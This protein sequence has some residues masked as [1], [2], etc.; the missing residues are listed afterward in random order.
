MMPLCQKKE[1]NL[2]EMGWWCKNKNDEKIFTRKHYYNIN[3]IENIKKVFIKTNNTG[4]FTSA[5]MYNEDNV[6]NDTYAYGDLYFDFDCKE[7]FEKVR[8]DVLKTLAYLDVV[9]KIKSDSVYI[10]F[11]GNKGIHITIPAYYFNIEPCVNLNGI[12]KSIILNIKKYTEY[13]TLDTQIYDKKRLYRI[14]NSIH[15][16]TNLYKIQ[17]TAKEIES[18]EYEK[19]LEMAKSPRKFSIN[20]NY[21]K[22]VCEKRFIEMKKNFEENCNRNDNIKYNQRINFVPPCIKN[23]LISG[24]KEGFRN[25]TIAVLASFYKSAGKDLNSTINELTKWNEDKNLPPTKQNELVQTIRSIFFGKAQYGCSTIKELTE[26]NQKEC[27]F[28]K[29][30]N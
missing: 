2:I 25:N 8:K 24:A 21:D 10:Y 3:D 16:K 30:S 26:C 11:S 20:H 19:I 18:L 9:F 27:K 14:P 17:L 12:F 22:Q 1:C 4:I 7:D 13:K 29:E 6:T 5:Y 23:I 28:K 15:D